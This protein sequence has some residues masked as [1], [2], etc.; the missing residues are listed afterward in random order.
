MER[1]VER[2]LARRSV[3]QLRKVGLD[4]KSFRRGQRYVSVMTDLDE[5]R[6]LEVVP[7]NSTES[8]RKLWQALPEAQRDKVEA[9]AMD[10]SAGFV[11]ATRKEAPQAAIVHDR[12]HVSALLN[13]AVDTVRRKEHRSLS[14]QGDKSLSGSRFLW[15]RNSAHLKDHH[16]DSFTRLLRLNLKTARAWCH[17]ENLIG[18]WECADAEAAKTYFQRWYASAIRSRLDPIKKVARSL[19]ERLPNL[20]TFFEHRITNAV[21]EGLNGKIQQIKAAARGFRSFH[22]YRTRILFFCGA[23]DLLPPH[24]SSTF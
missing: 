14:R 6:V 1:A 7:G 19:K 18:F 21:T 20:L 3:E 24:F 13:A 4:E 15:L 2:G 22:N 8:A 10:M 17:K 11:G 12:Y 9:A 5:P 23:L 16:L